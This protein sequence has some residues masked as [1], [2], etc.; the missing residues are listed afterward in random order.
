MNFPKL[1]LNKSKER[2]FQ[3]FFIAFLVALA[4]FGIYIVAD[5]GYFLYYGDFNV[6]QVSFYKIAH[7]AIREGNIFWNWNTD[8]GSNFI[9]SYSFYLL[10]SPFFWLTIPFPTDFVPHLMGPLL[11]LKFSCASLTA[12]CFI[13][14]FTK[15]TEAALIGGLLY[16]F[17]GFSIYNVFFNHFHEAIVFFPLL[18]LAVELFMCENK[19]GYVA[20]ATCLCALVNYYFFFGMILFSMLYWFI[21]L[22]S[23]AY[24]FK[25]KNFLWL[26]FELILGVLMSAAI[27][28]PSFLTVIANSRVSSHISGWGGLLYNKPQHF[29]YII[30]SFFFPPDNPARPVF[31]PSADVKWSSVAGWLP[32][33]G[34]TGVFAWLQTKKGTWQKRIIT[35]CVFIALIPV[36][37]AAF[38]LFNTSYYARWFYMPILIMALVTVQAFESPD[39]NWASAFRWSIGVT[40]AFVV[41]IG[42][43]PSN[44]SSQQGWFDFGLYNEAN[45]EGSFYHARFW[46]E[47]LIALSSQILLL[48]FTVMRG[49]FRKCKNKEDKPKYYSTMQKNWPVFW[50][51]S[52]SAVCIISILYS[53]IHIS[54]GKEH[55]YDTQNYIIPVLLE[56]EKIS[57]D[58]KDGERTDVYE[59]MDNTGMFLNYPCIQ[60]FHSVV[61]SSIME[62]WEYV[63]VTRNVASRPE[64]DVY[65]TRSLLNCRYLFDYSGDSNK[66]QETSGAVKMPG[67]VYYKT[68]NKYDIYENKYYVPYGAQYEYCISRSEVESKYNDNKS[69]LMLKGMILEDEDVSK[70]SKYI[71]HSSSYTNFNQNTYFTDC[72]TL[73]STSL[74]NTFTIDKK[75]GS[76]TSTLSVTRPRLA[77][78]AIPYEDGWTAYVDGQEVEIIKANV[79]FMA[80]PVEAGYHTIEFK[81]MTPGLPIGALVSLISIIGLVAYIFLFKKYAQSHPEKVAVCYPEGERLESEYALLDSL[82][83][84]KL[85]Q[86]T[87]KEDLDKDCPVLAEAESNTQILETIDFGEDDGFEE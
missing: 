34:M 4:F 21:R 69:A 32:L 36:L 23:G 56:G 29:L 58:I 26:C 46:I 42:L 41:A 24:K 84:E 31:F 48:I 3:A 35:S 19:R 55:S 60:C 16:A 85:V 67:F 57:L 12:Y 9:G 5:K 86:A 11:I 15:T 33:T 40:L 87:K 51:S 80:I 63:G 54:W 6:Q 39:I 13:R 43:F 72:Q 82:Y 27:L 76:F 37:N 68:Q 49:N 81:Y 79:G 44:Y 8:L 61:P 30:Q 28:M 17:S 75:T 83:D 59:G 62:F 74:N 25:I 73:R 7:Q 66:F 1:N 50:R 65:H 14:R 20:I 52:I 71:T 38:S 2:Y 47:S 10:G 64:T 77:F 18:L 70:Y 45:T 22:F 78:Y 53:A